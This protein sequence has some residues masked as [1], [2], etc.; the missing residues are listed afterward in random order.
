V[1]ASYGAPCARVKRARTYALVN[2]VLALGLLAVAGLL[3]ARL[4]RPLS[5]RSPSLDLA[6]TAGVPL[7]L[8]GLVLGP[9]IELARPLLRALAPL[10]AFA[11]GWIG[12]VL[13][14]RFEWRYARRIPRAAWLLAAAGA[15][16][17]F[18]VV[19]LGA[20]L[21]ARL[22]PGLAAVW[23][24]RLP[25]VLG[26]AAVAAASGP[27]AVTAVARAVGVERRLARALGRAA[28]LET[29]CAALAMGI[30]LALRHPLSWG[31]FAAGGGA[32]V[33]LVC[34]RVTRLIPAGQDVAPALVGSVLFGAGI[35]YATDVSP[36][37]VCALAA[38]VAVNAAPRRREVRAALRAWER[39]TSALVLIIS[40]ALLAL[41]TLWI[42]AAVPVLQALRIGA[43]WLNA[44]YARVA[45][46]WR[47]L[48]PHFGLG[49]V[50]QGGTA[51]ALAV[52]YFIMYGRGPESPG[53][54]AAPGGGV[55][56]MDAGA[57][58]LTTMVL[59]VALAQFAAPPLMRLALRAGPARLTPALARAEL[60]T[61]A[62]VD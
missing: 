18:L 48:P 20:W 25:A 33:G 49:T 9:G 47:D 42:I 58:V 28:A 7:I 39:P 12:A 53:V 22:V 29:A 41:P 17:A 15:G 34:W 1:T 3:A 23:T 13:G 38:V 5:H 37:L 36:F 35:G 10:T 56:G 16:A 26:I 11:I 4:P 60:T 45:L 27:E 2:P 52:N 19:A 6:I 61:N 57:A 43:R 46:T 14:A 30:P 51:L 62:P 54:G 24:P 55:S 50:A 21:L 31:V 40:G 44:R 59:G 8:L 32:L